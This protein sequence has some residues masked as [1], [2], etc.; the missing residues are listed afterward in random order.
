MRS[1][2]LG[3][4][5]FGTSGF[6]ITF[7]PR[8]TKAVRIGAAIDYLRPKWLELIPSSRLLLQ[9]YIAIYKELHETRLPQMVPRTEC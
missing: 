6:A 9:M 3:I 7:A 4:C 8:E 2:H 5:L 1:A